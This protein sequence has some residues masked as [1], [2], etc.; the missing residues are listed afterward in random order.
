MWLVVLFFFFVFNMSLK[1]LHKEKLNL[2]HEN[3]HTCQTQAF[4]TRSFVY[5]PANISIQYILCN[6][7]IQSVT[8]K[9]FTRVP[10][11]V[12]KA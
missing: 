6:Y 3:K 11:L 5:P 7:Q 9:L 1:E 10:L 4:S 8:K 12:C 2:K